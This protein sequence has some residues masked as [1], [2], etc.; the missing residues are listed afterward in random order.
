MTPQEISEFIN[1]PTPRRVPLSISRME[2]DE[3]YFLQY[4]GI[5]YKLLC[6]LFFVIIVWG[7]FFVCD[8]MMDFGHKEMVQ[9]AIT[10]ME[11]QDGIFNKPYR[12][13]I[14]F[15]MTDGE[16]RSNTC[17]VD[18]KEEIP[19]WGI[20]PETLNNPDLNKRLKL[21]NPFSIDVEYIPW[22]PSAAR[23][24]GTRSFPFSY[25]AILIFFIISFAGIPLA[26]RL[27][28]GFRITKR[29]LA[30]GLFTTGH[31]FK[32]TVRKKYALYYDVWFINQCNERRKGFFI[33]PAESVPKVLN[34]VYER[35][36]VGLLYLP[37]HDEVIITDLWLDT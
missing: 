7:Q 32:P 37:N 25:F 16:M 9:G 27:L 22:Y 28:R 14:R 34:W 29:L 3:Y 10:S 18:H 21:K 12:L 1:Q 36:S 20:I 13:W 17:H 5:L 33:V 2:I 6:F 4:K 15:L 35:S 30:D 8:I 31:V 23:A 11:Y 26:S 19:G 24:V